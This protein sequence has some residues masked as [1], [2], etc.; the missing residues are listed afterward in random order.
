MEGSGAF[1]QGA[2]YTAPQAP[3]YTRFCMG[4]DRNATPI[5]QAGHA[6]S[7]VLQK[8]PSGQTDGGPPTGADAAR[9]GHD[10]APPLFQGPEGCLHEVGV[11][12]YQQFGNSSLVPVTTAPPQTAPFALTGGQLAERGRRPGQSCAVAAA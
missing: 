1:R 9:H 7:Q 2:M 5:T 10:H 11:D 4:D 8:A 6:L 3:A 12:H